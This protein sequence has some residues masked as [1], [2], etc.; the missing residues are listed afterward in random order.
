[1]KDGKAVWQ[2]LTGSPTVEGKELEEFKAE[3]TVLIKVLNDSSACLAAG[4]RPTNARAPIPPAAVWRRSETPENAL[5]TWDA[6]VK[7]A[8]YISKL[9]Q[10]AIQRCQTAGQEVGR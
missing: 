4:L 6:V 2:A 5:Y 1:M 8:R 9:G 10:V 7:H 3:R